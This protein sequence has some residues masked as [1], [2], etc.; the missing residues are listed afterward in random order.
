MGGSGDRFKRE[1]GTR[2]GKPTPLNGAASRYQG[3]RVG[4]AEVEG[5]YKIFD[6]HNVWLGID[7]ASGVEEFNL[8]YPGRTS[9]VSFIH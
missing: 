7:I 3:E 5:R 1:H 6:A 4:T 9:L 2:V 8:V